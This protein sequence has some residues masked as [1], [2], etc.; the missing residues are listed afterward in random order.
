[1]VSGEG[2]FP[3]IRRSYRPL[4]DVDERLR[5]VFALLAVAPAAEGEDV[6]R[7]EAAR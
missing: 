5:R 4:P 2:A 3:V 1:M 7:E 6:P